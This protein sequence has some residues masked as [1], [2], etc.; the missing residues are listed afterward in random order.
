M[1]EAGSRYPVQKRQAVLLRYCHGIHSVR[2]R[3]RGDSSRSMA[4]GGYAAVV[5][6]AAVEQHGPHLPVGTD[7]MICREVCYRSAERAVAR[8]AKLLLAPTLAVGCS[9]HHLA[10][11]GTLSFTSGTYWRMLTDIGESLV[12]DGFRKIIFLN[13]HGGNEPMMHQAAQDLAVRHP[14]WTAAAS[15]WSIA[16]SALEAAGAPELGRVPGHAGGFE[17]SLVLAISPELVKRERMPSSHVERHWIAAG[18]AGTFVGRHGELTGVSGYTD[19][20]DRASAEKGRLYLDAVTVSVGD[21]CTT[22]MSR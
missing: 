5:P 21:C 16:R 18:P 10:F 14:V 17:R 20:A 6:L 11:G 13:G 3:A 15:Y 4:R 8:G 1:N 7:R 22:C 9:E 12:K 19:A 2:F